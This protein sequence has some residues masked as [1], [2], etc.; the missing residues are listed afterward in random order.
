VASST[1]PS[2]SESCV[3]LYFHVTV[4]VLS[5]KGVRNPYLEDFVGL[6]LEIVSSRLRF[7]HEQTSKSP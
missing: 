4:F 5:L 6:Y 2:G 3:T 7:L 1:M